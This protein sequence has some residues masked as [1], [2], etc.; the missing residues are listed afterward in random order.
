MDVTPEMVP[1]PWSWEGEQRAGHPL[2]T[3]LPLEAEQRGVS[4]R[5]AL[6]SASFPGLP[7][8]G[9]GGAVVGERGGPGPRSLG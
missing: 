3:V 2:H 6:G 1:G 8:P 9:V 5:V 7:K 4:P